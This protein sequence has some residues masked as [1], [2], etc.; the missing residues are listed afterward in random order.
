L[1]YFYF[2]AAQGSLEAEGYDV[3]GRL[4]SRKRDSQRATESQ[5]MNNQSNLKPFDHDNIIAVS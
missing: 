5:S 2:E 4:P 3:N 1:V